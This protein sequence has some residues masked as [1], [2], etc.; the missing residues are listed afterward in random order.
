MMGGTPRCFRILTGTGGVTEV[1]TE[2]G[3]ETGIGT[4]TEAEISDAIP[5]IC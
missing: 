5:L 1:G 2:T 4:G 3:I